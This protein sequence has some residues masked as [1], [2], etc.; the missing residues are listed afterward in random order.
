MNTNIN[1]DNDRQTGISRLQWLLFT[2]LMTSLLLVFLWLAFWQLD[3]AEEKQA[4]LTAIDQAPTLPLSLIDQNSPRFSKV[5]GQGYYDTEQSFLLDNQVES[6]VVGVH[7]YTPLRLTS[8]KWLL[9][10]RGWLPMALDRKSLP[11]FTTSPD[12]VEVRGIL[13]APPQ[14]GV[15]L[16]Q[17]QAEP[18]ATKWPRLI[19]YLD[20]EP[21]Q[22]QLMY[23]L[24]PQIL[25]LDKQSA[26]GYGARQLRPLNFGPDKH[27]GYALTWFTFALVAVILFIIIVRLGLKNE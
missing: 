17:G 19:T 13:N 20:L 21:V 10:N 18:A 5:S 15:R 16:G 3:R 9:V 24:M 23:P 1:R 7:L 27:R 4:I 11:Q 8:G 22:Q 6:N 2:V 26:S 12:I 14:T 25:Q